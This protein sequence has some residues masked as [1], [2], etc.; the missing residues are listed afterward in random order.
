MRDTNMSAASCI[1]SCAAVAV[2]WMGPTRTGV[3]WKAG[4]WLRKLVRMYSAVA[5][6]TAVARLLFP[7]GRACWPPGPAAARRRSPAPGGQCQ[8]KMEPP[9]PRWGLLRAFPWK[10]S[11]RRPILRSGRCWRSAPPGTSPPWP[12]SSGGPPRVPGAP[13]AGPPPF[14]R[15]WQ[16]STQP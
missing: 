7:G 12:P 6:A 5:R 13:R 10:G 2:A 16:G 8:V 3:S 4:S 14:L 15:G 1:P 9:L 11:P